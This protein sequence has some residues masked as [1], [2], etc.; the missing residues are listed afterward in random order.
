[1]NSNVF[2]RAFRYSIPVL[3]GYIAIGMAFG[4]MLVSKE[5][6]W[7]LALIMSVVMYA[8]SGQY[9]AVGLLA[10]GAG[11]PEVMLA[12]FVLNARHIAYG[13]TMLKP[14]NE[15]G[16]YKP[17]LIFSLT[18][19]TFALLSSLPERNDAEETLAERSKFI[20]YVSL[21]DQIYWI[22]G[23]IIGAL[24]GEIIPFNFAGVEFA[25]SALFIVLLIEQIFR[26]KRAKPF[27]IS[28]FITVCA[29]IFFPKNIT[30]ISALAISLAIV[31]FSKNYRSIHRM[32]RVKDA[33]C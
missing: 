29:V 1:M 15:A 4:L 33:S 13:I 23:S 7:W 19:E 16:V 26:V 10:S 20:F 32:R 8:G 18:D 3:L 9:L 2:S 5:Y 25:L 17:Y 30:L 21:L 6:P 31:H 28:G 12:Q 27:L 14:Y 22:A 24:A 11:I